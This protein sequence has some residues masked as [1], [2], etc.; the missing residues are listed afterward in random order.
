MIRAQ[1][2]FFVIVIRGTWSSNNMPDSEILQCQKKYKIYRYNREVKLEGGVLI[3]VDSS[4]ASSSVQVPSNI[5][6]KWVTLALKD[7]K[8]VMAA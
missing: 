7:R 1:L 8:I 5:E 2:I 3:T 4:I 6:N